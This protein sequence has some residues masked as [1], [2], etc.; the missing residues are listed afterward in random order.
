MSLREEAIKAY[1]DRKAAEEAREAAEKREYVERRITRAKEAICAAFA[2]GECPPLIITHNDI[3]YWPAVTFEVQGIVFDY[4]LD[5]CHLRVNVSCPKCSGEWLR[6]FCVRVDSNGVRD[7]AWLGEELSLLW[8]DC[9]VDQPPPAPRPEYVPP[10][11]VE[12][13]F[14][15]PEHR[16]LDAIREYMND[17]IE[18]EREGR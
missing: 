18:Q 6:R 9:P 16:L 15:S 2:L 14:D 3:S 10:K 12:Y 5:N 13:R 4:D 8:H 7:L 17:T 11:T 1:R